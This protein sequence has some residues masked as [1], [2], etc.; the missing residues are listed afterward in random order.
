MKTKYLH[1]KQNDDCDDPTGCCPPG[2]CG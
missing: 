2:C 1:Y